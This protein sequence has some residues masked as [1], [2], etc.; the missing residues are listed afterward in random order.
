LAQDDSAAAPVGPVSVPDDSAVQP[1]GCSEP[2]APQA[3][4]PGDALARAD[5]ACYSVVPLADD[6]PPADY[7]VDSAVPALADDLLPADCSVDS[8][9]P[10]L[11]DDSPPADCWV[12]SAAPPLADDLLPAD[13]W[14]DSAVPARSDDLPP[15]DCSVDSA[16]PPLADDLLPADYWVDSAVPPLADDLLP[17]DYSVGSAV[18]A[19]ADGSLPADYW[20]GSAVIQA[21]FLAGWDDS[22]APLDSLLLDARFARVDFP[23]GCLADFLAVPRL[24]GPVDPVGRYSW[25]GP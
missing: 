13:C 21:D 3:G 2:A 12:D 9:V 15:A 18:P 8:A 22:A 25:D 16:V 14:V 5:S 4:L 19:L 6:S 20:V 23:A 17:A 10:P 11:A 7:W 24:A 1:D